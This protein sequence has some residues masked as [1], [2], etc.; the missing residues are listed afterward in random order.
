MDELRSKGHI[1]N[2]DDPIHFIMDLYEALLNNE[3]IFSEDH[4]SNV[5]YP[6]ENS[7]Y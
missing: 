6:L 1:I 3:D 7:S 4:L 5:K 2:H